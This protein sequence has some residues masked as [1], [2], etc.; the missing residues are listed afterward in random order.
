MKTLSH[1]QQVT[2]LRPLVEGMSM[3]S[4][5]RA[6]GI[7][8]NTIAALLK[9]VG[10]HAKNHHDGVV[11]GVAA[12]TVQADEVWAYCGAKQKNATQPPG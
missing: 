2:I 10:A 7:A 3:R 1:D 4:V 9:N 8:R 5:A 6:T 11:R 12:T